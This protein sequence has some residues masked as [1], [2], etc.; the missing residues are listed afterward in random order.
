MVELWIFGF[1]TDSVLIA[2]VVLE[3]SFSMVGTAKGAREVLELA[4]EDVDTLLFV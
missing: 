4:T 3:E 2:T 1:W